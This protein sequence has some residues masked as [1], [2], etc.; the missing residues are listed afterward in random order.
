MGVTL[1]RYQVPSK[2]TSSLPSATGEKKENIMK[3]SRAEIRTGRDRSLIT[4]MCKT[5]SPWEY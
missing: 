1:V 3:G 4:V 5:D 2:A